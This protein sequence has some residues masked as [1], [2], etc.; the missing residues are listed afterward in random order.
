MDNTQHPA[1]DFFVKLDLKPDLNGSRIE[2]WAKLKNASEWQGYLHAFSYPHYTS[3]ANDIA[4]SVII[5][6]VCQ[7]L[8]L[9]QTQRKGMASSLYNLAEELLQLKLSP[10]TE[11]SEEVI[12]FWLKRDPTL[13]RVDL[14]EFCYGKYANSF[15]LEIPKTD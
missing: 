10:S 2:V 8:I 7:T 6:E 9:P 4:E 12:P 1:F 15:K 13:K 11:L 14:E 3:E 5:A